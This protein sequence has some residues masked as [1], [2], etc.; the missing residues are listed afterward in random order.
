M[1]IILRNLEEND[2][3]KLE[4]FLSTGF[5]KTSPDV[6]KSRFR[7]WWR[8]NPAMNIHTSRGWILENKK[9]EIVGFMGNVPVNFLVNGKKTTAAA[10]ASWYVRPEVQ[11]ATSIL[12]VLKFVGQKD[13]A[14]LLST[15]PSKRVARMNLKTGFSRAEL[16][17]NKKEYWY[18]L[19]H[20]GLFNYSLKKRI[21]SKKVIFIIKILLFPTNIFF[22]GLQI[23]Q[24]K[25]K[26]KA[27]SSARIC[28]ICTRC[29][30]SFTDLWQNNIKENIA[31]LYRDAE[32]LNW[33][34]FSEAVK[35]KRYLIQCNEKGSN[36]LLGYF[37]FDIKTLNNEARLME[38]KDAFIP[39]IEKE[40]V[41]S[42]IRESINIAQQ[43]NVHAVIFWATDEA[44][45]RVLKKALVIRR[46]S[47]HA[48]L[49]KPKGTNELPSCGADKCRLVPSLLDPDR[50]T[51]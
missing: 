15:T 17:Y 51:A 45:D 7:M 13:M 25:R 5:P 11:G 12:P 41:F 38:L 19:N 33:L 32:N 49:Y 26:S 48:Y 46:K 1:D 22:A 21:Q 8:D 23:L 40:T 34:C 37:I 2:L 14:V 42:L 39:I 18:V 6:W 28:S 50:G 10:A 36:K 4:R 44:L 3:T 30:S 31:T 35:D 9:T 27:S 20:R 43:L 29:G 47:D 24:N 16:P